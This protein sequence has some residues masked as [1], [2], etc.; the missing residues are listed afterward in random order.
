M[1]NVNVY[2]RNMN[3]SKKPCNTRHYKLFA[4]YIEWQPNY[5]GCVS[6]FDRYGSCSD[7]TVIGWQGCTA[8][9]LVLTL[10]PNSR[11]CAS[12]S[13]SQPGWRLLIKHL[14]NIFL[15]FSGL[16]AES[17]AHIVAAH[18]L[19]D[20]PMASTKWPPLLVTERHVWLLRCLVCE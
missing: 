1:T 8:A 17:G 20:R 11:S 15:F 9:M 12:K 13:N 14:G 10:S 2:H 6:P 19:W 16:L 18:T 7:C 4:S 3:Q 5:N